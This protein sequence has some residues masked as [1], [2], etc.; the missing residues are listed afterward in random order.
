MALFCTM[1][2][3]NG[4]LMGSLEIY[5]VLTHNFAV[6]IAILFLLIPIW[7]I[8]A[9]FIGGYLFTPLF[10]FIHKKMLGRKLIYGLKEMQQP[11][12][13]KGAFL[14]CFFPALLALNIG[15][16]LS[17]EVFLHDL[18]FSDT[19]ITY[20]GEGIIQILTL[21]FLFPIASGI[22]IAVFSATYFLLDS[23]I[24]YTNKKRKKVIRG[25]FPTEVRSV[26][27]FYLY[28]LKGYAGLSVVIS[29]VKLL[30][31]FFTS[32]G[33]VGGA[34]YIINSIVWP[35]IP[36]TITLFMIPVYMIQDLTYER[37]KKFTLKWAEK[38]AI[39]GQL[40]DPLGEN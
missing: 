25:S 39:R 20:A 33:D 40:E 26:G 38:F 12:Q 11:K 15:I 19:F 10:L 35:L 32:I 30:I 9:F 22:G 8:I 18:L 31:T 2:I 24:E 13:F 14:S 1:L 37:R 4:G 7:C 23:G 21:V 27:G 17:D 29:I 28:Y 36:F 3:V 6:D 16:L 34:V 5:T